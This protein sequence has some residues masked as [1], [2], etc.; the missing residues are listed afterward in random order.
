M[1]EIV[2]CPQCSRSLRVPDDLLGK[3][4]KCPTCNGMFVAELG[5]AAPK[6]A[7]DS[8]SPPR[9]KPPP[10][11]RRDEEDGED[12]GP[13]GPPRGPRR[14]TVPHRGTVVL[15]LGI[16]SIALVNFGVGLILGPVAWY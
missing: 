2:Q 7:P 10:R 11:R 5:G 1:P 12:D 6:S 4:V 15:I 8:E 14:D 16:L 3:K 9:P 13:L